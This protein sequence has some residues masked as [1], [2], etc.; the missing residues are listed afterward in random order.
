[1]VA[2]EEGYRDKP[3]PGEDELDTVI[4]EQTTVPTR[5]ALI[6]NLLEEEGIVVSTPGYTASSTA[7]ITGA[8]DIAIRVPKKDLDRAR[9]VLEARNALSSRI[10]TKTPRRFRIAAL[11][12]LVPGF[13]M[14]HAHAGAYLSAGILAV[15][16]VLAF[17]SSSSIFLGGVLVPV[18]VA[19]DV[20]GSREACARANRDEPMGRWLTKPVIVA[21]VIVPLGLA[22]LGTWGDA[23]VAGENGRAF[24]A[25]TDRCGFARSGEEDCLHGYAEDTLAGWE[26]ISDACARCI[27]RDD[28]C[29]LSECD[30]T[31]GW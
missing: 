31:C 5:A 17:V 21:A 2:Q 25:W 3:R 1:M 26:G 12:A 10:T 24:C 23:L 27:Q 13:G 29:E 22:A 15:L 4:L 9:A 19:L 7:G 20:L 28:A 8:F 6:R 11:A 16:E 30:D 14:G 18:V